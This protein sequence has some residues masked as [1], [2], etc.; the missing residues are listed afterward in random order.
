MGI[1]IP[2]LPEGVECVRLGSPTPSDFY[3]EKYATCH[4][5]KKPQPATVMFNAVVVAP[6]DGYEFVYSAV[7]NTYVAVK[8][9]AQPVEILATVR[10]KATN[11]EDAKRIDE[12][13][14]ALK[15]LAGFVEM[16]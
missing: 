2:G 14:A 1:A 9:L 6:A 4:Q 10:F 15:Q 5:I 8:K 11:A 12:A 7:E 16:K 13:I 3:I